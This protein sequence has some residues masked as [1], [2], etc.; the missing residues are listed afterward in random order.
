MYDNFFISCEW[1][2]RDFREPLNVRIKIWQSE[3]RYLVPSWYF[4]TDLSLLFQLRWTRI[5]YIWNR[6]VK[7]QKIIYWTN[8][9]RR[10]MLFY[11]SK[12]SQEFIVP[13][14]LPFSGAICFLAAAMDA[15]KLLHKNFHPFFQILTTVFDQ[16]N[17]L[18]NR[19]HRHCLHWRCGLVL[20]FL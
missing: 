3:R 5:L 6:L 18:S 10:G 15:I 14:E 7:D 4:S 16:K 2:T 20:G 9:L 12:E 1:K 11:L 19:T 17:P 13:V 8:K